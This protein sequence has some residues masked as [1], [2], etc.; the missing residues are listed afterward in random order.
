MR[1]LDYAEY[2]DD[3]LP[4]C[5][6]YIFGCEVDDIPEMSETD[7]FNELSDWLDEFNMK[8]IYVDP[9]RDWAYD[10]EKYLE[11]ESAGRPIIAIFEIDGGS[12]FH[13]TVVKDGYL[14]D[15]HE[16]D[17][18]C[19]DTLH[20]FLS[21][22]I[23]DY[24]ELY[25]LYFHDYDK[26]LQ[27]NPQD[28]I[29][30]TARGRLAPSQPGQPIQPLWDDPQWKPEY[31]T[32]NSTGNIEK[33]YQTSLYERYNPATNTYTIKHIDNQGYV[34]FVD[35]TA[36]FYED[37]MKINDLISIERPYTTDTEFPRK[38]VKRNAEKKTPKI[39]TQVA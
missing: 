17:T 4:L 8:P 7:W 25:T 29:F 39:Q 21:F 16:L 28:D 37:F 18:S 2:R 14:Y 20:G 27:S 38:I 36:E 24:E 1:A 11:V 5:L 10:M 15:P 26:D 13:A 34:T 23:L 35:Q 22:E 32:W 30:G 3:C 31:V 9:S 33:N 6:Q 12:V 19:L